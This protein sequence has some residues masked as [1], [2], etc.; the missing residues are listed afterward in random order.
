MLFRSRAHMYAPVKKLGNISINT[1]LFNL[2][3]IWFTTFIAAMILYFDLL[4][5][6]MIAFEFFR[7]RRIDER[8]KRLR[9]RIEK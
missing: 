3:V 2:L 9:K 5:K 4:R 1:Y 8:V 7:I 6:V